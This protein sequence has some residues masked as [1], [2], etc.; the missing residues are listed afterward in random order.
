MDVTLLHFANLR[1]GASFPTLALRGRD[2]R[3]QLLATLSSLADLAVAEHVHAVLI[4]GDLFGCPVPAPSTCMS[5]Q[6]F[7]TK[8]HDCG[9]PVVLS[10][11]SRDPQDMFNA[12]QH[13]EYLDHALILNEHR[14]AAVLEE[15]GLRFQRVVLPAAGEAVVLETENDPG[16]LATIGVACQTGDEPLD[17]PAVA[18]AFAQT[19]FRYLGLGGDLRFATHVEGDLTVCSPGVPEPL[20]WGQ[21]EGSIALVRIGKDTVR[22][23]RGRTGTRALARRDLT[24][25]L[26]TAREVVSLIAAQAHEDLGLEVLLRG[27][28]PGDVLIDPA[29]IEAELAPH[30]FNLRV[31]DR[32]ELVI[33]PDAKSDVPKGTVLGNFVRVM[34][35]RIGAATD[36]DRRMHERE[37][38][39]LGMGLLRGEPS[40]PCA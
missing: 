32:T 6:T 14:P 24:L 40:Q 35:E 39:R 29:A 13:Q 25:T 34:A 1:L 28:C 37:A 3:S 20:V 21:E 18:R 11:G 7:L 5:V 38:Y 17:L 10:Q 9:I 12:G 19:P 30:F 23:D 8:L 15:L 2:Q 36:E 27:Q 16:S 26:S 33:D 4:S 31:V 22:V